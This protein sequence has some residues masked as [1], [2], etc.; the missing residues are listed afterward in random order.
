MHIDYGKS[1]CLSFGT[2]ELMNSFISSINNKASFGKFI[3]LGT[4]SEVSIKKIVSLISSILGKD[5]KIQLDKKRIRPKNSEV[6]RLLASNNLAKKVL[7]W[8]PKY[9]SKSGLILALEKTVNWYQD[10]LK[11][12]DTNNKNKYII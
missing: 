8:K 1:L 2:K 6:Q 12:I 3:N 9:S 4:N 10:N 5:L 7:K 11:R